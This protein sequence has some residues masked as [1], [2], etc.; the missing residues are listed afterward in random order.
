MSF[1]LSKEQIVPDPETPLTWEH[2][3]ERLPDGILCFSDDF[4]LR[5][6]QGSSGEPALYLGF[7]G[8][9]SEWIVAEN[10][11]QNVRTVGEL[12]ELIRLLGG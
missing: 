1:R 8:G 4:D 7:E 6:K 9:D 11:L 5:V 2:V 3:H 10:R 12:Q